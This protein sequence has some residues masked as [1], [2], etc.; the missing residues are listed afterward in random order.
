MRNPCL[1]LALFFGAILTLSAAQTAYPPVIKGARAEVYK[2]VGETAL[3]LYIFEPAGPAQKNRPAIV[4]FFGGGWNSGTPAQFEPQC[5]ALAARGIVA[6]TAD[7][8][9]ATRQKAKP[10]DCVADAKSAV[11]WLRTHAARLGLDPQRIAAAGGSAGG[12]IAAATLVPGPD[13]PGKA[14]TVSCRPD[15]LVL[16]NPGL[17]LAPLDGYTPTGFGTALSA[18]RLGAETIALSP[19]HHVTR[20][21]P[22]TIIFHGDA[23]T[24]IPF[25]ASE[26]FTRVMRAA[27]NRCELVRF[28]GQAHG[29]FNFTRADNRP[30]HETL[31]A[32][33]AFLVSLGYLPPPPPAA[34][35]PNVIL[36]LTDDLGYGD[37]GV[38]GAQGYATPHLDRLAREGTMFTNF[39][40]AQAVCSASR[41]ALLTGAYSNRI[42]IHG[43]LGPNATHGLNASETTLPEIFKAR[44]YATGMAGKWHLGHHAPFQPNRHGFDESFG[45]PYSNDM[46]PHHPE[47]KP[48]TYP[49]LPLYED[50]RI[51][52]PN[53]TPTTMADFTQRFT[54]RAVSFINR[55][56]DQPFFFYLAHPMPHVPLAVSAAFKGR[57]GAGLYGDVMME[58]DESVGEILR[59]LEQHNLTRDTLVIFTSDNGPWLSYGNHA[60]SAGSLREGKGTAWEGGTRVPCLMRWPGHIPAN[61]RSDAYV[62]TIDWLPTLARLIN[63]P[64]PALP[65]DGLDVWPLLTSQP[66]ASNPH[67]GYATWYNQN[68]LQSVTSADG[69]WKLLLAHTYRTL[70]G[71]PGGRDGLP[72]KYENRALKQPALFDLMNDRSETADVAAAHPEVVQGL[73]AFAETCRADLGDSLTQRTGTGIRAPGRFKP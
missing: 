11:R 1:A 67:A 22:P 17:V 29:F 56:H 65:I 44:G 20:G 39:H 4:F 73:L 2:T 28:P 42:G 13:E 10:V 48:G 33:D 26:V 66:G 59:T 8:R 9:V 46:W 6:I 18:E 25:A 3:S 55:H 31:A 45:L 5:R 23:D 64:L 71:R 51:I 68:E 30:Y 34:R 52:D 54:A 7:Y 57:S 53:V 16:F 43:A 14:T 24:T 69:Q 37:L 61:T 70:A 36:I 72:S 63:A 40:V 15:A 35:P 50:G 12:H 58:L 38:Y 62:M 47:A 32:T 60:G 27:G 19:G 41:A 49:P 21:A